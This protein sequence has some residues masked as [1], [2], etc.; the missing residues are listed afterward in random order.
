M[1]PDQPQTPPAP[2]SSARSSTCAST[3][4]SGRPE[5]RCTSSATTTS[6]SAWS[7]TG[8]SPPSATSATTGVGSALRSPCRPPRQLDVKFIQPLPGT[9]RPRSTTSSPRSMT[10]PACGS[11]AST[12][13]SPADRHPVPGLPAGAAPVPGGGHPDRQRP[14]FGASFHWPVLD[15]GAGHVYIKRRTPRLNGKVERFHRID[16][17]EFYRLLDGV[18]IDDA[19]VFNDKLQAWGGLLQLP[20]P[21]RRPRGPD[22]L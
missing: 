3:T 15:R 1:T 9:P 22:P 10:A 5:S 17:E 18:V 14:E 6:S 21:P 20:S 4:T 2:T 13:S 8:C 16:A 11:C 12:P 19:Q 7:S